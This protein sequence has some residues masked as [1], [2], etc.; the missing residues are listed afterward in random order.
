MEL[1][2]CLVGHFEVCQILRGRQ[3]LSA[4]NFLNDAGYLGPVFEGLG[5]LLIDLVERVTDLFEICLVDGVQ[6]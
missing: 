5:Y 6:L 2:G 4:V 1:G 3:P